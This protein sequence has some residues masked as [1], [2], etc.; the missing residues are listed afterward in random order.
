MP[1]KTIDADSLLAQLETLRPAQAARGYQ[2]QI[3]LINNCPPAW[4]VVIVA[5]GVK[6]FYRDGSDYT[7]GPR[8][9]NLSSGQSATFVSDD[10]QKCVYQY[11][12]AMTVTVPGEGAQNMTNQG[13]AGEGECLIHTSVTL[14]P[15]SAI[16]QNDLKRGS[17]IDV[18]TLTTNQ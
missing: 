16:A 11:F 5:A 15:K 6:F 17:I 9:V 13:S 3:T 18:L 4:G 7:D 14:G 1:P 12:L 2:C 10:A 8:N